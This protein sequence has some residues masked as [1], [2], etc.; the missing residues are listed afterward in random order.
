MKPME[1][2]KGEPFWKALPTGHLW[3]KIGGIGGASSSLSAEA[4]S[5]ARLHEK[6]LSESSLGAV[7]FVS[8]FALGRS[9]RIR[10]RR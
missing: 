5:P 8:L 6:L 2:T 4:R 9:S 3:K 1:T 10:I 7:Q